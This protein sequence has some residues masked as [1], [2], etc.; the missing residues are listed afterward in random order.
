MKRT[1]P[2]GRRFLRGALRLATWLLIA[3]LLL[4]LTVRDRIPLLSA[5]YYA[6]PYGILTAMAAVVTIAAWRRRN[7]LHAG[8]WGIVLGFVAV[9]WYAADWRT[10]VRPLPRH[11]KPIRVLCWNVCRGF[12]G[13]EN[14]AAELSQYDADVIVLIE[15]GEPSEPMRELWQ[16]YCP[17]YDVSLLGGGMVCLVRGQSGDATAPAVDGKTQLRQLDLTVAEQL[18]TCLVVDANSSPFYRRSGP[19]AVIAEIA[20]DTADRPLLV[21]GDFNTPLDSVHLGPLRR[22]HSNAYEESGTG[23]RPTWPAPVPVLSLDQV[24]GNRHVRFDSCRH[25]WSSCS[26]HRPVVAEV[27]VLPD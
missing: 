16:Q 19:L 15:A 4:R 26:D 20:E 17:G 7:R 27:T 14:I 12:A 9:S 2:I 8:Y 18:L 6:L 3:G 11:A 23:Y 1:E 24:W 22:G 21:L 10:P 25:A 5:L 13:W